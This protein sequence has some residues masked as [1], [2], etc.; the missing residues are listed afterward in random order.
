MSLITLLRGALRVVGF[1]SSDPPSH[2]DSAPKLRDPIPHLPPPPAPEL[3]SNNRAAGTSNVRNSA[4]AQLKAPADPF[5]LRAFPDLPN[6]LGPLPLTKETISE[7]VPPF[8]PGHFS[9]GLLHE[10][11]GLIP[12]RIGRSSD[13]LLAELEE[14]IGS[15][16]HFMAHID[17]D[18][19]SAFVRECVLYHL[20]GKDLRLGHPMR[21]FKEGWACPRCGVFNPGP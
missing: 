19:R 15:A 21:T 11:G 18:A 20:F 4:E 2:P 3:P 8:M 5:V 6:S 10:S 9:L 17:S 12:S 1:T 13:N 16:T 14:A 7:N